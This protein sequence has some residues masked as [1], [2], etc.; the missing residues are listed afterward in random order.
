MLYIS[1][2]IVICSETNKNLITIGCVSLNL[3]DIDCG[4]DLASSPNRLLS[5]SLS[6]RFFFFQLYIVCIGAQILHS[7]QL[8][9]WCY[10]CRVTLVVEGIAGSLVMS[11]R[12]RQC[13]LILQP[14]GACWGD[15]D[16]LSMV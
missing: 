9:L 6:K 14:E 15:G 11:G 1:S 5:A 8:D 3:A 13:R 7:T 16:A 2:E 10:C 12:A 4:V